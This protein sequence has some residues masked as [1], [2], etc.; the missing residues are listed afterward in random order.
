ML[1]ILYVAQTY[2]PK[3]GGAERYIDRLAQKMTKRGHNVMVLAPRVECE[4]LERDYRVLRDDFYEKYKKG[5]FYHIRSLPM[6]RKLTKYIMDHDI[7]ILHFQYIN[8][9]ADPI[10]YL[11]SKHIKVFATIHGSGIHFMQEDWLGKRLL[12]HVLKSI[13]GVTPVSDYCATL[14]KKWGATD[15]KIHVIYNGTDPEIFTPEPDPLKVKQYNI[16]TACRLV[17]RKDITTLLRG[18]ELVRKEISEARLTI[19]G[20]G[21][22]RE[23]LKKLAKK[24][25]LDKYVKFTGFISDDELKGLYKHSGI[26]I[27]PAKYDPAGRD[28]EGFGITLLEAMSSGRPVIGANVGGIPSAI[29]SDWGYLYEPEAYKELSEKILRLMRDQ[30]LSEKMGKNGRKAVEKIYN[31]KHIA[32]QMED[33]YVKVN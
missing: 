7:D 27:L 1:N 21:P 8:P 16:L 26:F 12:K 2:H 14:A 19:A 28:I 5:I 30:N 23:R 17:P 15:K 9:F 10:K 20:D 18:F 4:E 13:N 29:K 22:D 31:W 24:M 11:R 33:M 3:I 6:A 32:K 25:Q